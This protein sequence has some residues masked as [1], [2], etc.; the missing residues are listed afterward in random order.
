MTSND[1]GP[2]ADFLLEEWKAKDDIPAAVLK[3]ARDIASRYDGAVKGVLFYGS[4]LRTGEVEDK[5][6]DFYVI[7]DSYADAYDKRWLSIANKLLPPNVFYHEIDHEGITMRS[8]YAILSWDDLRYRCGPE[9]LNVSVWARFCQ[10][11]CPIVDGANDVKTEFAE[12]LA[13]AA[14]TMLQNALPLVN[15]SRE[16]RDIWVRAF[17]QTYSAELR[18]E[19]GG[20]GLEIYL[21]DQDR[22]DRMAPLVLEH[23]GESEE[24]KYDKQPPRAPII[25]SKTKWF[26]RKAN[27]K[28]VSVMRLIKASMTF[29]G[30]IDYLA[31]KI[32]RHSGV[33]IEITE[34]MR[35]WP[36]FAGLTLFWR[37]RSRGA[38]K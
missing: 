3:A 16:S 11:C 24:P 10:P 17:S 34:W 31:W 35:K 25:Q 20:K 13:T 1:I 14:V 33:E 37:L 8:K 12:V 7:V 21:L 22:Y 36:V 9:C 23:L 30:G 18:S 32:T 19:R 5:V 2:I 15:P 26:L 38:F 4:C 29:D 28:F 6:L 27:G